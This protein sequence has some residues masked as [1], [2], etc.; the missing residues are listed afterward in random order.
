MDEDGQSSSTSTTPNSTSSYEYS[1]EPYEEFQNKVISLAYH[2]DDIDDVDL[3]RTR[4]G[5]YNRVVIAK[6]WQGDRNVTGV[7]RIPRF[8]NIGDG[9]ETDATRRIDSEIQDQAAVLQFLASRDIPAPK[10]LAFDAS[11]A[12]AI[13]SPFV[14][15]EYSIGKSLESVYGD[16]S[17]QEKLSI[18]DSLLGFLLSAEQIQFPSI[19]TLKATR[20]PNSAVKGSYVYEPAHAQLELEV[21]A[22]EVGTD[23]QSNHQ[24]SSTSTLELL[25]ELLDARRRSGV[26]V[27]MW[28]R[29][30]A[31]LTEMQ[32]MDVFRPRNGTPRHS[33][34][35]I[36]YHWDLEPRNILVKPRQEMDGG[37]GKETYQWEIDKVID[38]DRV[39][40][41]PAV[42]ARKPPIWLW[43]FSSNSEHP[44]I[45]SDFDGDVDQLT[46]S[47]YDTGS[48]R[49]SPS[50][51]EI[52]QHFEDNLVI[53]LSN[54]YPGYSRE[55]YLED[56]YGKGRWIR[57]LARFAIHG[58]SDSQD[59]KRFNEF[60]KE[61]SSYT[62]H[63]LGS[64]Q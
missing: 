37:N 6:L 7:F 40:A 24:T 41:V 3:Q 60:D 44:S 9:S 30:G 20:S 32:A 19:G 62:P 48:G 43:D 59:W 39:L 1:H 61:W 51:Q 2:L 21:R 52:R 27:S 12:N 33:T 29:L 4:G 45:A 35:S 5:S 36:L 13:G 15:Q 11:A 16:M 53:G 47:R 54:L 23:S 31:I 8:P 42:L 64:N 38:W 14:F 56:T 22:F 34:A 17:L 58:L 63:I 26:M 49:L 57:R 50:D 10:L 55:E 25:S 18:V 46:P 28:R